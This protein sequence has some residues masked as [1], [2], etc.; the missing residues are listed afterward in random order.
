MRCQC[1]ERGCIQDVLFLL[2]RRKTVLVIRRSCSAHFLR[3]KRLQIVQHLFLLKFPKFH[4]SSFLLELYRPAFVGPDQKSQRPF[5]LCHCSY[6]K[7]SL[8]TFFSSSL[9]HITDL[10]THVLS[11]SLKRRYNNVLKC[12]P[13][14]RLYRLLYG[15]ACSQAD[16]FYSRLKIRNRKYK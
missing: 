4:Y 9:E 8:L 14:C 16:S 11:G 10:L 12:F 3:S 13:V 6:D 2:G 1:L 7:P 5:F 15:I